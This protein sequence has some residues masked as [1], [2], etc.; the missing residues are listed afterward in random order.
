[1]KRFL[2]PNPP[3]DCGVVRLTGDDYHYLVR[4]RR[5]SEGDVFTA[6]LPDG[7]ET[8]ALVQSIR[9][10]GGNAV[11]CECLASVR[12]MAVAPLPPIAL[13]QALPKGATIDRIIR[14]AAEIGV[15]EI[16]PFVS[17]YSVPK[18]KETER[19][20]EKVK[21]WKRIVKEARQ[22]SGS[23]VETGISDVRTFDGALAYWKTT[24]MRYANPSGI[25]L[26]QEPLETGGGFHRYLAGNPDFVAAVVGPEGGFSPEE[27]ERLIQAGFKPL[28]IGASVLR[29]ETAAV[30]AAAAIRALLLENTEWIPKPL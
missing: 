16:I 30:Y 29:A 25:L 7:T 21:R 11:I 24:A 3:D 10:G 13:F 1:M 4:V 27:A 8:R 15:T 23:D 2:L 26:H 12:R 19:A 6:L 28:V 17:A 18:L 22:Q 9:G 14:Q 20:S 5:L